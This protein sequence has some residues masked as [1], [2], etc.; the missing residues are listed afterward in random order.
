MKDPRRQNKKV[1]CRQKWEEK[2]SQKENKNITDG[3]TRINCMM[4][5]ITWDQKI[6]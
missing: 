4:K 6:I 1:S 3:E 2:L 5:G